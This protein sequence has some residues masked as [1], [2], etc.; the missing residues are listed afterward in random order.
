MVIK[1]KKGFPY[2]AYIDALN[3]FFFFYGLCLYQKR[4]EN[5]IELENEMTNG[6]K[7]GEKYNSPSLIMM[8]FSTFI[9]KQISFNC[10]QIC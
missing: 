3:F 10:L 4:E 5:C 2:V 7:T 6:I 8:E 1:T 9:T